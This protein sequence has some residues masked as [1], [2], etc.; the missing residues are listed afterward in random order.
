[1]RRVKRKEFDVSIVILSQT[2]LNKFY[3]K[4]MYVHMFQ[5]QNSPKWFD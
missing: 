2:S 4:K 1:M 3:S 5:G